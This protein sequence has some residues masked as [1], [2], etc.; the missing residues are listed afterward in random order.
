LRP[1][2]KLAARAAML[3][4]RKFGGW[5]AVIM[6]WLTT[7]MLWAHVVSAS[8]WVLACV[9][10][11]LAGTVMNIDSVEGR[12]FVIRV[13]PKFNR[14]NSA[15]AAVLLMTGLV[16]IYGAGV[17]R[18]FHF[19]P[20]FVRVLAIK[21]VLYLIMFAALRVSVNVERRLIAQAGGGASS[22]ERAGTGRLAALAALIALIGAAA[23][24]LG[25][26]LVGE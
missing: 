19:P 9:I 15:A 3:K 26:W 8:W 13:V 12:G 17:D 24:L 14:A 2:D 1:W 16:N 7:V 11:A 22:G 6:S 18:R 5:G 10:M 23:M 21:I 25:V 4:R 20:A